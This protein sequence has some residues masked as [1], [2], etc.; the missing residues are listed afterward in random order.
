MKK[1]A[2]RGRTNLSVSLL[3]RGAELQAR[4]SR[5]GFKK[6]WRSCGA[7]VSLRKSFGEIASYERRQ[8]RPEALLV[9][10]VMCSTKS[11][12]QNCSRGSGGAASR[13]SAFG[14]YRSRLIAGL[15]YQDKQR[16]GQSASIS[17]M[18]SPRQLT[19]L[20]STRWRPPAMVT[21]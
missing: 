7:A 8:A 9:N 13:I 4:N 1:K 3:K 6:F 10:H 2:S 12:R 19:M 17:H 11:M 15:A 14:A 16:D 20:W 5:M 21:N 18:E